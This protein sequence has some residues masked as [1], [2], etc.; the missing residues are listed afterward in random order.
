M[1][2]YFPVF[3]HLRG[4][5]CLVVGGGEVATRKVKSLLAAKARVLIVSP[6]CS[7]QLQKLEK[8]QQVKLIRKAY[9]Q[10]YL[11]GVFLVIAASGERE[12]N[13]QVWRDCLSRRLLVNVVDDPRAGNLFMPAVVSRGALSLAISTEGRS[14]AFAR[15]LKEELEQQYGPEYGEYLEVLGDL[16]ERVKARVKDPASRRRLFQEISGTPW[17][18]YFQNHPRRQFMETVE[19]LIRCHSQSVHD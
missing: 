7:D 11:R 2:E 3:L 10:I 1:K 5:K 12:V 16:R 19:A 17:F 4:K 18:D 9:R 15:R 13:Q 8:L 6:R 14:P